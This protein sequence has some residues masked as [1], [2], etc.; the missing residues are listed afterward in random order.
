MFLA[1]PSRLV[2][3][4]VMSRMFQLIDSATFSLLI[5]TK[6]E[7]LMELSHSSGM[8][9]LLLMLR[10]M[11]RN[12]PETM[13][14]LSMLKALDREKTC[15]LQAQ[16]M[17][18]TETRLPTLMPLQELGMSRRSTSTHMTVHS[19]LE[20]DIS[21]RWSGK[22][23]VDL[24]VE[25]LETMLFAAIHHKVTSLDDSRKMSCQEWTLLEPLDLLRLVLRL[26]SSQL[27]SIH[28]LLSLRRCSK[29]L[30][31]S[32]PPWCSRS[33]MTSLR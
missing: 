32:S 26:N 15:T 1:I 24:A 23:L 28:I 21:L 6:Q 8:L 31:R 5:T 13:L 10:P 25:K 2:A 27:L 4:S 19:L 9:T 30:R 17:V 12:L 14:D 20:L 29:P 18:A 11:L 3:E 16:A 22:E 33:E 7:L